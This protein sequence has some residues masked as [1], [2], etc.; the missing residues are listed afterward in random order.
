MMPALLK[1]YRWW[2]WALMG[3]A[4]HAV[5]TGILAH[6]T[7]RVLLGV[8][9]FGFSLVPPEDQAR[10]EQELPGVF[11]VYHC[12]WFLFFILRYS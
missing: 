10:V 6:S 4:T 9:I 12:V 11:F 2:S 3:L 5:V 7:G 1:R 8:Y